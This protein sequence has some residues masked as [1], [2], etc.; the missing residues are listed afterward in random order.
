[1][2][3]ARSLALSYPNSATP[4]RLDTTWLVKRYSIAEVQ[5]AL[6][7]AGFEKV[8]V[9]NTESELAPPDGAGIVYF[10]CRK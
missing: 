10:V 2:A 3:L 4:Q 7:D 9:D 1:M 8:S 5:S 6:N